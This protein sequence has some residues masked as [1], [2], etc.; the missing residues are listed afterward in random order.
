MLKH[1]DPKPYHKRFGYIQGLDGDQIAYA[2]QASRGV[3]I[4]YKNQGTKV[5][6]ADILQENFTHTEEKLYLAFNGDSITELEKSQFKV[7]RGHG[8]FKVYVKFELKYTYFENL[9]NAVESVSDEVIQKIMPST[10][11]F[12]TES[13]SRTPLDEKFS[14]YK[15]QCSSDQVLALEA[16]VQC[17]SNG[18]PII[19]LGPFGTGKTRILAIAANCFFKESVW[20]KKHVR[21]LVCTQQRVSADTFYEAYRDLLTNVEQTQ[22]ETYVIRDTAY[23][24]SARKPW[25]K[26][27]YKSPQEFKNYIDRSSYSNRS[28]FLIIT[29]CLTARHLATFLHRG[30]FTH[31]LIDEGAQM[32]EPEAIA[33]LLLAIKSTKIVIAGDQHQV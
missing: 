11:A 26:K 15:R 12:S 4:M 18:P 10:L 16:I 31:I 24:F 29:T 14:M 2:A 1:S 9:E 33:P 3:C 23:H 21:I 13:R 32:R 25:Y 5:C 6:S 19:I 30:F 27:A 17:P 7:T 8:K 20:Q 22:A 28:N